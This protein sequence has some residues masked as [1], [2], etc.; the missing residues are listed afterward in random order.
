MRVEC[1]HGAGGEGSGARSIV[2]GLL[3]CAGSSE[4][5]QAAIPDGCFEVLQQFFGVEHECFASPL[6]CYYH[7]FSSAFPNVDSAFGSI[8]SFFELRRV[9]TSG[10]SFEANP[11]FIEGVMMVVALYLLDWLESELS[12]PLSFVLFLPSGGQAE[13][14]WHR[15]ARSSHCRKVLKFDEAPVGYRAGFSHRPGLSSIVMYCRTSVLFLRNDKGHERWPLADDALDALEDSLGAHRIG[16]VTQAR[17]A[18]LGQPLQRVTKM[19]EPRV[20]PDSAV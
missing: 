15:M 2:Y 7:S 4:G 8:G 1:V 18:Q 13:S 19:R 3:R 10:G 17:V 16:W 6:N 11:P 20:L 9:Y 12:H 5:Y 14:A